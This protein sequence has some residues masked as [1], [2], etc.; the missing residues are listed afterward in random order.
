VLAALVDTDGEFMSPA[1]SGVASLT[2]Q[3]GVA[4]TATGVATFFRWETASGAASIQQG[5]IS[6]AWTVSKTVVVGQMLSNASGVRVC[7]VAGTT[8]SSG[9]GPT[10]TSGSITDGTATFTFVQ[11]SPDFTISS[12]NITTGQTVNLTAYTQTGS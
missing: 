12:T 9:T 2:T 10:A 1:S 5:L 4:A 6:E 7:S 3:F 8:A 11:A